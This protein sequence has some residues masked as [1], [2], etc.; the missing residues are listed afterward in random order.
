MARLPRGLQLEGEIALAGRPSGPA[1]RAT[2]SASPTRTRAS[3]SATELEDLPAATRRAA[4]VPRHPR[5]TAD[6]H[7]PAG[8]PDLHPHGGSRR[9][10]RRAHAGPADRARGGDDRRG[11]CSRQD[12]GDGEV[13][14]STSCSSSPNGTAPRTHGAALRTAP[15]RIPLPRYRKSSSDGRAGQDD[16]RVADGELAIAAAA[17]HAA[18]EPGRYR[19]DVSRP[20]PTAR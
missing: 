17:R 11:R 2:S 5:R 16:R 14:V 7:P 4:N 1:S 12:L 13:A 15:G 6:L 10:R 9:P 20:R 8:S 3:T 19:L 18:P